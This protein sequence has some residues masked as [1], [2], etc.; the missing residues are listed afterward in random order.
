MAGT[1]RSAV[2]DE[3]GASLP[4]LL[5]PTEVVSP[6]ETLALKWLGFEPEALSPFDSSSLRICANPHSMGK[7][8]IHGQTT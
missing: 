6:A 3:G 8:C 2:A 4:P 1:T 5:G 7:N